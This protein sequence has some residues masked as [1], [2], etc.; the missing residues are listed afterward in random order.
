MNNQ[1]KFSIRAAYRKAVTALRVKLNIRPRF[2]MV[3]FAQ[4]AG[5]AVVELKNKPTNFAGYLD[6]HNDPCFI[7]INRDLQAYQQTWFIALQI[8]VCAHQRRCNSIVMNKPWK[9][10]ALDAAPQW[11]QDKIRAMDIEYR[12]YCF[13]LLFSNGDDYR[14]F[15]RHNS[16]M[17][18]KLTFMDNVIAYELTKL[19]VKLWLDRVVRK[20]TAILLPAV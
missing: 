2:T 14:A 18:F 19:R 4:N 1:N 20:L 17:V 15:V 5:L 3:Q 6:W 9:W 8:A 7:A 12:A 16:W 11:I 10:N 13:M